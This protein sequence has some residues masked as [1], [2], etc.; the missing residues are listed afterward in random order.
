MWIV[1]KS[2]IYKMPY[3]KSQ[4][5]CEENC[6]TLTDSMGCCCVF[7]LQQKQYHPVQLWHFPS[8]Y[9]S[10][11]VNII[12]FEINHWQKQTTKENTW[13]VIGATNNIP[14]MTQHSIENNISRLSSSIYVHII[15]LLRAHRLCVAL[16]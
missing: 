1:H 6:H 8:D 14:S 5:R 7:F 9:V 2:N 16:A 13:I 11:M 4:K 12:R 10:V 15:A 3:H